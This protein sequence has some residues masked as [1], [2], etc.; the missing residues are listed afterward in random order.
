MTDM[1]H[2]YGWIMDKEMFN[3]C[4]HLNF[5]YTCEISLWRRKKVLLRCSKLKI[6]CAR[7]ANPINTANCLFWRKFSDLYENST[8]ED[9]PV[10]KLNINKIHLPT[11]RPT[12]AMPP[13][14]GAGTVSPFGAMINPFGMPPGMPP[15]GM[16]QGM[17][18]V[19]H[20]YWD[21]WI[22]IVAVAGASKKRKKEGDGRCL[23]C[24]IIFYCLFC[25]YSDLMG[26]KSLDNSNSASAVS[27]TLC[28]FFSGICICGDF[29]FPSTFFLKIIKCIIIR[30]SCCSSGSDLIS[31]IRNEASGE[32]SLI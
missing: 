17:M 21:F 18:R 11:F 1:P 15:F 26:L 29:K 20:Y 7:G 12:P 6:F 30:A 19:R 14:M 2:P 24:F 16:P 9:L 8:S 3:N 32:M 4:V 28:H 5:V 22:L 25:D 27:M 10:V 13:A 31:K 23:R